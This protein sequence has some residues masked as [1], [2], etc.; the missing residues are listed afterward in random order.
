[1]KILNYFNLSIILWITKYFDYFDNHKSVMK[2]ELIL[3]NKKL[4]KKLLNNTLFYIF[5]VI[6]HD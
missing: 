4:N 6:A 1:M 5:L 3:L 2:E